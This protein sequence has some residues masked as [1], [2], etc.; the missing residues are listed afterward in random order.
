MVQQRQ[1]EELATQASER[2]AAISAG[3]A[4][5]EVAE[6]KVQGGRRTVDEWWIY[7]CNEA[8]AHR[9]QIDEDEQDAFDEIDRL[10]AAQS[11]MEDTSTKDIATPLTPVMDNYSAAAR[12][13][14]PSW[15]R[16]SV[17]VPA[18]PDPHSAQL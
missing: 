6:A 5:Y 3:M 2:S 13:Q 1:A 4:T 8:V 10:Q 17:I 11:T 16:H 15:I 18:P 9:K 12:C 14:K 7:L